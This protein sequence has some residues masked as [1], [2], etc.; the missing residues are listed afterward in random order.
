MSVE[1]ILDAVL[2]REGG[3]VN[4]PADKGGPTNFGITAGTLGDWRGLGRAATA[5]EVAALT[6]TEARAIYRV[7]YVT[8]PGFSQL[9][10][11]FVQPAVV[12]A[13][14]NHGPS[15]A[16]KMLERALG[17]EERG[18]LD[19]TVIVAV[20]AADPRATTLNFL[21]ERFR[22]YCRLAA[23]KPEQAK[24]LKGWLNRTAEQAV[25]AA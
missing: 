16:V 10:E 21:G 22:F 2:A 15:A 25:A 12:D 8:K 6:E 14:V 18:T 13:G 19:A 3:F 9:P 7:E 23:A 5:A 4:D 11:K 24:F 17:L 1:A 20:T